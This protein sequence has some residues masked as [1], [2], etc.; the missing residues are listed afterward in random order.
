MPRVNLGRKPE[1]D[2]LDKLIWGAAAAED[3]CQ[4]KVA[5]RPDSPYGRCRSGRRT[6]ANSPWRSCGIW[7]GGC[8]FPLKRCARPCG[9]KEGNTMDGM[10]LFFVIVGAMTVSVKLMHLVDKLEGRK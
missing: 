10:T 3:A 1:N 2:A 9:I 5:G 8:T 4:E 6:P 7:D